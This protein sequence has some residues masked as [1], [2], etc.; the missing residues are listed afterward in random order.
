MSYIFGQFCGATQ[1]VPHGLNGQNGWYSLPL[2]FYCRMTD[3]GLQASPNSDFSG[4]LYEVKT[5]LDG[6]MVIQNLLVTN[7]LTPKQQL[8]I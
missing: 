7:A 1:W 5:D 4:E 3:F 8:K 2:N 6:T